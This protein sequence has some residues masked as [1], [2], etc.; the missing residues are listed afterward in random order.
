MI[1]GMHHALGNRSAV[2]GPTKEMIRGLC[3]RGNK[4]FIFLDL[5]CPEAM[6]L[7]EITQ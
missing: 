2:H 5:P 3:A 6:L 1:T 4:R 7:P